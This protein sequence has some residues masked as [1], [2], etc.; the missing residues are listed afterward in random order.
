LAYIYIVDTQEAA[1]ATIQRWGN[2]L[3]V[4]L[5]KPL[6]ERL[7]LDQGMEVELR[8]EGGRLVIVPRRHG[9]TP[10]SELLAKCHPDNRPETVD[11]GPPAGREAI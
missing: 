10:L 1:M 9:R 11:F 7:G 3:A 6:A 8:A 4:R 5:P 2:S